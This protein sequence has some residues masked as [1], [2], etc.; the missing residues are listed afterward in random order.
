MRPRNRGKNVEH[1]KS[2][3]GLGFAASVL[4]GLVALGNVAEAAADWLTYATIRDYRAQNATTAELALHYRVRV[5]TNWPPA[6]ITF[7]AI[8][9]FVLWLHNARVNAERGDP[10]AEHRLRRDWVW[11]SWFVPVVNLWFPKVVV[12]DVWRACDPRL[13]GLPMDERPLPATTTRWWAAF[14]SMWVLDFAHLPSYQDGDPALGSYLI[15]AVVT[16]LCAAVGI[17]AAVYAIQVVRQISAFQ[18]PG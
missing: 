13:R 12:D 17:V 6:V 2:V 11:L 15:A 5:L 10:A 9:V 16:T 3:R 8:T 18:R 4:I 1:L 14:V 7:A